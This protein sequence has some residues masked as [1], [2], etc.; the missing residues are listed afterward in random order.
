MI[1]SGYFSEG[2]GH[3]PGEETVPEP[4]P[5]KVVVFE[6]F[7]AGLQM[8]PHLVLSNILLNFQVQI[9]QLTPNAIVQLSKYIW[10]V[11]S[12]GGVPWA[13]GFAKRYELHYQ[14]RKI[15]VDG[16]EVQGQYGCLN[17]HVKCGG[18]ERDLLLLSR[19]NDPNS[20]RK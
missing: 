9:H 10:V 1:D 16:V 12:F 7:T 18:S 8:P 15:E 5:D 4:N 3:E 17:F 11:T 20:G 6:F 19:T 2:M 13:E 14:P